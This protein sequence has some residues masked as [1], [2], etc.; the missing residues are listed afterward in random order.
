M[1]K[2]YAVRRPWPL[3]TWSWATV[4]GPDDIWVLRRDGLWFWLQEDWFPL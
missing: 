4:R 2:F 1:S 3:H